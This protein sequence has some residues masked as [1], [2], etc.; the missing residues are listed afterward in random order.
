MTTAFEKYTLVPRLFVLGLFL[1]L[2]SLALGA[3][4]HE[5]LISGES[6][7]LSNVVIDFVRDGAWHYPVHAQHLFY[8][9]V[10]KFM[11][12]P[13]LHY[14]MAS[15][16]VSLFGIG[17]WQLHL[18]SVVSMLVGVAITCV[19]AKRVYGASTALLVPAM[20]IASVAFIFS[21]FEL[22]PDFTFGLIY[23]ITVL[24]LGCI[25]FQA[26]TQHAQRALFFLFGVVSA[27]SLSAH[28]FG[29]F[30]QLY[31]ALFVLLMIRRHGKDCAFPIGLAISGWLIVMAVWWFFFGEDFI[32]SFVFVLI[33]GNDFR[34]SISAPLS[35]S[36]VF[37]TEWSGGT[38]LT[39]GLL[40]SALWTGYMLLK[41]KSRPLSLEVR[42]TVFLMTNLVAY[43]IFYYFFVGNKHPQYASNILLLIYLLAAVGY[44]GLI[45]IGLSFI[46]KECLSGAAA[47]LLA[48]SAVATSPVTVSYVYS[49]PIAFGDATKLYNEVRSVLT[50]LVPKSANL[51]VG[52]Q[53]YPYLY[54]RS[55]SSTMKLV[56]ERFLKD[57]GEMS[58][59]EAVRFYLGMRRADYAETSF[60]L[61][62]RSR[63]LNSADYIV[64]SDSGSAWQF[65]FYSAA[66]WSEQFEELA[67]VSLV[68]PSHARHQFFPG[69]SM[70][71]PHRFKVLIRK[72]L[73]RGSP[74][75][76]VPMLTAVSENILVA[77]YG[78]TNRHKVASGELW[79]ILDASEQYDKVAEYFDS[80]GWFCTSIT[81]GQKQEVV[82]Q[83]LPH[84]QAYFGM[85]HGLIYRGLPMTRTLA[86]AA[87][88]ALDITGYPPSFSRSL[89]VY[90]SNSAE[91]LP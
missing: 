72:K 41:E 39:A 88:Y 19:T 7:I 68:K 81:S 59:T 57:P 1:F 32:R 25:Y 90:D 47:V 56:A 74:L 17:I 70:S 77:T 43:F 62:D 44:S 37:L 31:M 5:S 55:Y 40:L 91:C 54:D 26:G 84:I 15:G 79:N 16:W 20:A 82:Q 38:W 23:C 12:H 58:L 86:D 11:I 67:T 35:T 61:V 69:H 53:A 28:W 27:L 80:L 46:K 14:L 75:T 6:A 9:G 8:P 73:Q 71:Y 33:K 2:V 85:F 66:V 36:V 18:Q 64:I 48:S 10:D 29:F 3:L 13:P 49:S 42:V 83:L 60:S 65:F 76:R 34:S 50:S 87:D 78:D 30:V 51:I 4:T 52:A 63:A 22:R 24:L 45:K 21:A 89:K